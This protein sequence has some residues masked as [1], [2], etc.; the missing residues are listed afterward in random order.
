MT[1]T[2]EPGQCLHLSLNPDDDDTA[3]ELEQLMQQQPVEPP[4]QPE[5][6]RS[7]QDEGPEGALEELTRQQS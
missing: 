3:E 5:E 1:L 6:D 7:A 4:S 2:P